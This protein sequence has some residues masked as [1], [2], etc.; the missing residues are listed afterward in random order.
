MRNRAAAIAVSVTVWRLPMRRSWS[1]SFLDEVSLLI[2]SILSSDGLRRR[3]A[4][5][6]ASVDDDPPD[7]ASAILPMVSQQAITLLWV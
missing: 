4:I 1:S 3:C 7:R 6:F 2:L 5:K